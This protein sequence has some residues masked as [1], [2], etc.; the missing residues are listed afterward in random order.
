MQNTKPIKK[1]ILEQKYA[2]A[3]GNLLLMLVLTVINIILFVCGS[4]T[5]L[6]FSATIP[7]YLVIF[8]IVS[9]NVTFLTV[10]AFF[11][12]V[13][14]ILY[15]LCWIF[16]KKH[17]GWLIGA[18]VM[19][20]IDTIAMALMYVGIGEISGILDVLIHIWVLYYL[21][22]GV[23]NGVK[24][25]K[26]KND[27]V[28]AV[29]NNETVEEC[30]EIL[31]DTVTLRRADADVKH[32]VLLETEINGCSICYRR[33]KRTNELVVNGYVYDEFE[34]LI[35]PPHEL[36]AIKDGHRITAG[37]NGA[38]QAFITFDGEQIAKK[39]RLL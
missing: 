32:R 28:F 12:A 18:L 17:Y 8:G 7:Y 26:Y 25:A 30:E 1:S 22:S 35:E 3:R 23:N 36:V 2:S 20:I 4:Y 29:E 11:A 5:M 9:E 37:T 6:L 19:F 31:T 24:L 39:Q 16:S 21:I 38:S 27:D 10:C 15:L 14:I 33:V 34:A 13:T